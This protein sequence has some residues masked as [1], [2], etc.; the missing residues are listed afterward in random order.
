M[1]GGAGAAG[2]A[3]DK[4]K[5]GGI[6]AAIAAAALLLW[7]FKFLLAFVMTKGKLLLLGLTKS[8]TF[9]SMFLSFG[10][11]WTVLGWPFALGLVLCIYVHEMGHVEELRRYVFAATEQMFVQ[12]LG[13]LIRL[14][15]RP[16]NPVE[17]ARIGLAGP[18]W[19]LGAAVVCYVLWLATKKPLF[20]ALTHI[21]AL[22][23]LFNLIPLWQLDGARGFRALSRR[24]AW[25]VVG[26][27]GGAW[28]VTSDG[29]VFLVAI[30]AAVV[31]A[32]KRAEDEADTTTLVQFVI[33]IGALAALA[34]VKAPVTRG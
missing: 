21:G 6:A 10:V 18:L 26:A 8:G 31:A 29:L 28:F 12:G 15:Q 17:D 7:K 11:Y 24:Q 1:P 14:R 4:P 16:V 3:H 33:L 20:A 13:A 19:G 22:L 27:L 23:N 30:I 25:L 32:T 9:L 5:V 2:G 34:T